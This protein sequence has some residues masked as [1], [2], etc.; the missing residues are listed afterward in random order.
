MID[1]TNSRYRV[2]IKAVIFNKNNE[3]LLCQ[4]SNGMRDFP[5]GGIELW[6]TPQACLHR[7]IQEEMW[8]EVISIDPRPLCFVAV[9]N[10]GSEK[11][12]FVANLCYRIAVKNLDIAPSD[13]C[14]SFWFFT[15]ESIKSLDTFS[16]VP[17]IVEQLDLLDI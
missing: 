6:E 3:F 12:P 13:E 10:N 2:S 14:I 8:L 15:K 7:E 9:K 4:E 16:P 5:G 11:R 17:A 1:L